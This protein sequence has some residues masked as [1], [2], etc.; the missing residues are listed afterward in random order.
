MTSFRAVMIPLLVK[1]RANIE[2]WM[3]KYQIFGHLICSQD[4]VSKLNG[5]TVILFSVLVSTL[6]YDVCCKYASISARTCVMMQ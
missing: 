5:P 3:G 4:T 1:I 2:H 6:Q